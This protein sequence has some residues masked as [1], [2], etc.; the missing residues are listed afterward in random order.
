MR[1]NAFA[2]T[3]TLLLGTAATAQTPE[4]VETVR[5]DI[6]AALSTPLPIT[7][8]GPL[9]AADIR[10][11]PEGDGF[12]VEL[13]NP[14]VMGMVPLGP[15]SFEVTPQDGGTLYRV[16]DFRLPDSIDVFGMATL[17]IG[18]TEFDGIWSPQTRSYRTLDFRLNAVSVKP[19]GMEGAE[20]GIGSVGL[21]VAK[22][23]ESGATESRI[24]LAATDISETGFMDDDLTLERLEAELKANGKEP[25]DLYA[26]IARFAVLSMM[27]QDRSQLMQFAESLRVRS[28]DAVSLGF[29]MEGLDLTG[30]GRRLAV[31]SL[32]GSAAIA[33]MT[34]DAWGR[35][36][37]DVDAAGVSDR[38]YGG[39]GRTEMAAAH[40]GI[41]G[42]RIPV[43]A[44]LKAISGLQALAEGTPVRILATD[45]LDGF[46]SIG[47]LALDVGGS[48]LTIRPVSG[49][50]ASY[51]V[52][53][54]GTHLGLDGFGDGRGT[55]SLGFSGEDLDLNGMAPADTPRDAASRRVFQTLAPSDLRYDVALSDLDE[56]LLR[57]LM[58]GL[59]LSSTDDLTGLAAPALTYVMAMHPLVETKDAH[60]ASAEIDMRLASK[61]R[62]YPAWILGALPYEGTQRMSLAGYDRLT[63]MLDDLERM[64]RVEEDRTTAED[65]APDAYGD[66]G[67]D[68]GAQG[69]DDG[70]PITLVRGVLGT[71]KALSREEDGRMVW[72]FV[73]PEAGR[74]LFVVNDVTLRYPDLAAFAPLI[75]YGWGAF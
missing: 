14:L 70:S 31:Q 24:A 48:G 62:V 2:L 9:I 50:V 71:M 36:A 72:D 74:P 43:G 29:R 10:V 23:G 25:V 15:V 53:K 45:V 57:R 67:F 3:L 17:G 7:V 26:V 34:P 49:D 51:Q 65:D 64:P 59:V 69:G 55:V 6:A 13:D 73:A 32:S 30:P 44:T 58:T 68:G 61:V 38:G 47:A 19:S 35:L 28:Y 41:A 1:P 63:A 12:R 40:V 37:F 4:T 11:T 22:E 46:L 21:K 16:T 42:A 56:A 18:S 52:G 54:V 39:E 66:D 75:G 27:Q 60:F 20:V 33:D 5:R 8:I